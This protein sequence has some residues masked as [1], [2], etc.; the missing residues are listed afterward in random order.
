MFPEFTAAPADLRRAAA[1][2]AALLRTVPDPAAAVPG[3]A[4]TVAETAAHLVVE[5]RHYAAFAAG[6]LDT[7]TVLDA[8]PTRPGSTPGEV[9]AAANALMLAGFAERDP[10]VLADLLEEAATDFGAA[11]GRREPDEPVLTTN[12]LYMTVPVMAATLLGEQVVHGLD[13]ARARQKPWPIARRDA[14]LIVEGVL[15]MAPEYVDRRRSA[16]LRLA[17]EL[18]FRGG[19]R[20]RFA[21]DD[22]TAV[23]TPADGRADCRITA[24]P[25]AFVLMGYGRVGQWGQ[26]LR[27]R[28]VAGGRKPWLASKFGSLLTSV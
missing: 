1:R 28:I 19:P 3:L 11:A 10:K 8:L 18:R 24:D 25:V 16:G 27:G 21:V 4:W 20:Y 2:T 14:L 5:L 9:N 17:Y 12:G 7:R 23:V 6:E 13:I 22:G 15:V 26:V